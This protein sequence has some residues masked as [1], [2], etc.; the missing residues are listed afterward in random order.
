MQPVPI[1]RAS[2]IRPLFQRLTESQPMCAAVLAGVYPGKVYVDHPDQPRTALLTTY[3]ESE[4]HGTWC[5]LAGE[6]VNDAFNQ[7]LNEAIYSREIISQDVPI[8]LVSC[9]PDDW[10]GQMDAVMAPRPPAWIPRYRFVSRGVGYDWRA[11]MPSGHTVEA[12]DDDLRRIPGLELPDDVA[13]TLAK[14]QAMA[15]P[16]FGDFGFVVLDRTGPDPV[17][18]SWATVDF[19]LAGAGD[20][21]FFTQPEYRRRGL[22]TVAACAALEQAFAFGLQQ[23]NW[24]CDAGNPGSTATAEKLGLER[25]EE[26]HQAVLIMDEAHHMAFF[27]QLGG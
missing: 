22:G 7:A 11:A 17:A 1:A 18:A 21:G 20:L 9:D 15:D 3:I 10:G 16:R 6:P 5:F 19:V 27:R 4:A 13:A 23:V 2:E 25:V 12:M 14:W 26:Y 8:L 24:T